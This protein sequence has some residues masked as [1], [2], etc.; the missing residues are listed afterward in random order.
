[1]AGKG[2]SMY[3][4]FLLRHCPE[5][6]NL[7][8]DIHGYVDV[9]TM[10]ARINARGKYHVS[11]QLL[12]EIVATDSK[13]R[14]R[15]SAD[16]TRIKACQGHSIPWVELE[17][18]YTAPPE[19][20][21]HG[22]TTEA[23]EGILETGAI[24][25]MKRHGVHMQADPEKAWKSARRWKG[26]HPVVLKIAAAEQAARGFLFGMSENEVWC[27]ERVPVEFIREVIK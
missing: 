25:R 24:L 23:L 6:L 20:L 19:F 4:S 5:D 22:T 10:I 27:C 26:K 7:E 11:R 14:Y 2:I 12:D 8:M 21:Y 17:L 15:Y 3:L 1:M 16:G 9:D 18:T 13:G